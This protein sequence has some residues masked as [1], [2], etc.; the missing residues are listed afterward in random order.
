MA[1]IL[2]LISVA[3]LGLYLAYKIKNALLVGNL[4]LVTGGVKSGKSTLSVCLATRKYRQHH[5]R[6]RVRCFFARL[7]GKPLPEEP[8]LFSN[9]PLDVEGYSLLTTAHLAR[10][11]RFP[12]KSVIYV[13]EASLVADSQNIR[14]QDLNQRLLEFNK[15]IAHE[16]KGGYLF[17]DTQ[18]VLDCH[19]SI[20]RSLASYLYVH[21]TVKWLPFILL[22]K[23]E[24]LRFDEVNTVNINDGDL[25]DRPWKWVLMSKRVWKRFDCYCYSVMT[26]HLPVVSD[27]CKPS[28]LKA[29]SIISLRKENIK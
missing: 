16:T 14:D 4:V 12:Y 11:V 22:C 17:Y 29:D 1:F 15:L 13:Q 9:V 26:D 19:Y 6:W 24:E 25:D 18:S 3:L 20:K 10:H 8:L 23:V 2:I 7:F 28:S 21:R 5:R 27:P